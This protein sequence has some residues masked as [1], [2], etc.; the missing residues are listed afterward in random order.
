VYGPGLPRSAGSRTHFSEPGRPDDCSA[1][2]VGV[3]PSDCPPE[4]PADAPVRRIRR[5]MGAP[6]CASDMTPDPVTDR[7]LG[8][9]IRSP[10]CVLLGT[11]SAE[12]RSA[13]ASIQRL[14]QPPVGPS[15]FGLQRRSVPDR[16]RIL[17]PARLRARP[18]VDASTWLWSRSQVTMHM[19]IYERGALILTGHCPCNPGLDPC[20]QMF[21]GLRTGHPR[22]A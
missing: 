4:Q 17:M 3:V 19:H 20:L 21:M 10:M 12:A 2:A 5:P 14:P 8:G 15:G 6:S 18:T 16:G 13:F 11:V 7:R 1:R 22:G 9:P